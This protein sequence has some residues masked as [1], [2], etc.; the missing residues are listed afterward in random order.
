MTSPLRP[1]P[2][3]LRSAALAAGLLA[4]ACNDS[5]AIDTGEAANA[6]APGAGASDVAAGLPGAEQLAMPPSW[7]PAEWDRT[8]YPQSGELASPDPQFIAQRQQ[9]MLNTVPFTLWAV[10]NDTLVTEAFEPIWVWYTALR[11]CE[12][13]IQLSEDL[14][15]EFGDRERGE[16]ALTQARAHLK[17]W[18]AT[19][20]RQMT[21]YFTAT[22]GQWNAQN[23]AFALQSP[24]QATTV[25]PADAA[26]FDGY[27]DGAT[28]QLWNSADVTQTSI[29][30]FQASLLAPQCPSSDGQRVYKF[31][32]MSQWWVVFGEAERGMGG[33]VNYRSRPSLPPISMSREEAASFAQRNPERKVEVGVTFAPVGSSFVQGID[34]S[35]I[36]A[37]FVKVTV[38]DAL[39][40]SV[41][42][43]KTY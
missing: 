28:V 10:A 43:S 33:L 23:G 7:M 15:G 11:S 17:R 37:K 16:A 41:L 19:Q 40:G 26:R 31:E 21:L 3:L 18:A 25:R 36:R 1:H 35:T 14:A 9:A 29:S 2:H 4:A 27:V 5:A 38:A 34:Q 13:G 20:P 12:R 6:L 30:H 32:K 22:L 24:G 39:D 8:V 42:A